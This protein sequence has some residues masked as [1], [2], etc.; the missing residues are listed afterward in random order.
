P[1]WVARARRAVASW[2]GLTDPDQARD[3]DPVVTE[4]GAEWRPVAAFVIEFLWRDDIGAPRTI[5]S[6]HHIE[7]DQT[8]SWFGL[9]PNGAW[10]W[11]ATQ[12]TG[13]LAAAGTTGS[14]AQPDERQGD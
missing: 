10:Q 1:R 13:A 9:A 5:T 8:R 12:A 3:G 6:A 2:P 7:L 4:P 11:V 14:R